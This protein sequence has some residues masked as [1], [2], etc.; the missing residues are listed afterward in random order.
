MSCKDCIR[1]KELAN[2]LELQRLEAFYDTQ[3]YK[4]RLSQI[5]LECDELEAKL[6]AIEEI[7]K[8]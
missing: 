2:E 6:K 1:I 3:Y 8:K 4:K 7:L 5:K